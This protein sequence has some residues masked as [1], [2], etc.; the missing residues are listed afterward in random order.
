M[1]SEHRFSTLDAA[2]ISLDPS[3]A[4]KEH[5]PTETDR[6]RMV[7]IFPR[8][9]T[10]RNFVYTGT[11]DDL[12][13]ESDVH[14]ITVEPGPEFEGLLRSSS[15][16]I[17]PL[18]HVPEP[19]MVRI[20]RELLDVAHNRWLWSGAAQER[21]RLR[22]AEAVTFGQ[23]SKR[24]AKKLISYPFA[25]RIGLRLLEKSER[26]SSR[27]L[28][29]ARDYELLYAQL[30]PSLVFNGSHVHSRNAIQAV[31][32]AQWLG[33][34]TATFIF[35]WDNLTSQ[36]RIMLPYDFFLVWNEPLKRQLLEMYKWIKPENVFVTGTPQFDLHFREET[37]LSREDYCKPVSYT[38]LTL[39][40]IYSV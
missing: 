24:A 26:V 38:H 28:R 30:R 10:L 23:R 21:S 17:H 18:L 25:N 6:K 32:A 19:W 35:S 11:L 12:S 8:G 29:T 5:R 22:D 3:I 33:I 40:T 7:V 4:M 27:L 20:Q 9:E 36:G 37:Y 2:I 16:Q 13:S 14:L 1:H 39:P 15:S 31:Q 34:P